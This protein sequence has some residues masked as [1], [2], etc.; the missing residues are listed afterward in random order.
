MQTSTP[1]SYEIIPRP[2]ELG[3]GWTLI[4]LENGIE[5]GGGV[6]PPSEDINNVEQASQAAYDDALCTASDWLES[7]VIYPNNPLVTVLKIQ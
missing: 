5:M 4:L 7:R 2:A 6:F 3:G 1:C